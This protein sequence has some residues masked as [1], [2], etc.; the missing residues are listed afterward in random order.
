MLQEARPV[1]AGDD[2]HRSVCLVHVLERD[3]DRRG[4][5]GFE[6]PV[7]GI[8]VPA[9]R[10]AAVR[11]LDEEVGSPEIKIR[12]EDV[13]HVVEDDAV[14]AYVVQK[15]AALMPLPYVLGILSGTEELQ[16]FAQP[17]VEIL[18]LSG[19]EHGGESDQVPVLVIEFPLL[20]RQP[21]AHC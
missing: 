4:Y 20:L 13:L 18:H 5:L 2:L 19:I 10:G 12:A 14:H 1:R 6:R 3:P 15:A 7:V 17:A 11:R 9:H 21:L 8:L 16:Q